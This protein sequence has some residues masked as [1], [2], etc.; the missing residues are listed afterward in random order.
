LARIAAEAEQ[1]ARTLGRSHVKAADRTD[2][3]TVS[4][5]NFFE[6]DVVSAI[7][8][9]CHQVDSL[10]WSVNCNL[11]RDAA[12]ERGDE[13]ITLLLI[14]KPYPAYVSGEVAFL[15]EFTQNQLIDTRRLPI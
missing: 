2:H 1:E 5:G 10:I 3:N 6:F 11:L 14:E 4:A 8:K 12:L 15:H 9:I 13:S 7:S